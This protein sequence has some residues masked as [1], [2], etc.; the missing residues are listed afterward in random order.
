MNKQALIEKL[1]TEKADKNN[2]IDLNAFAL[3]LD[4]MYKALVSS[5]IVKKGYV[6]AIDG[7]TIWVN[8]QNDELITMR[9]RD[10]E[11]RWKLYCTHVKITIEVI[12]ESELD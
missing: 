5:S 6:Q 7:E 9:I 8:T 1:V 11:T 4:E 10:K 2:T 12:D 3:G